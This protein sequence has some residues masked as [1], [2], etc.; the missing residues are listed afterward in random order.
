MFDIKMVKQTKVDGLINLNT[1][2]QANSHK[3]NSTMLSQKLMK[4]KGLK[5]L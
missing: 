3:V 5:G 1:V 4:N 2:I